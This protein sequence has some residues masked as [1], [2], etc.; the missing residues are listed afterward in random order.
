MKILEMTR[1]SQVIEMDNGNQVF[2]STELIEVPEARWYVYINS[3]D[4][5]HKPKNVPITEQERDEIVKKI[6]SYYNKAD[7]PIYVEGYDEIPSV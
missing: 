2:L 4:I 6:K 7:N 3:F 1:G 5:W